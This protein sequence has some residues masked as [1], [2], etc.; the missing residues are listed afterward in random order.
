MSHNGNLSAISQDAV[1]I[2]RRLREATNRVGGWDQALR[3]AEGRRLGFHSETTTVESSPIGTPSRFPEDTSKSYID[4]PTAVALRHR[5]FA[6]AN[7]I[8]KEN[9]IGEHTISPSLSALPDLPQHPLVD[10]PDK[11]ISDLAQDLTEMESELTSTGIE[12]VRW[13]ANITWANYGD[14][15]LVPSLVYELEFPRTDRCA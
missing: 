6:A 12:R 4:G 2:E 10:H 5:L 1:H 3:D 15:L 14:Y 9:G 8:P 13:P 11:Q 7:S